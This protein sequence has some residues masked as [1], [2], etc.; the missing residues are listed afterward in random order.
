[1]TFGHRRGRDNDSHVAVA[2]GKCCI[3]ITNSPVTTSINTGNRIVNVFM[4]LLQTLRLQFRWSLTDLLL[5]A[6]LAA[7]LYGSD[8]LYLRYNTSLVIIAALLLLGIQLIAVAVFA[9]MIQSLILTYITICLHDATLVVDAWL[10]AEE[11]GWD[12][13]YFVMPL[14]MYAV[15]TL[16][17]FRVEKLM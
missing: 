6:S 5:A 1:M 8:A 2:G 14:V 3:T 9:R 15:A 17:Y 12:A 11:P 4:A 13:S 10:H 16:S 7:V